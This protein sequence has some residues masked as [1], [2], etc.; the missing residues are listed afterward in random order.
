MK[1]TLITATAKKLVYLTAFLFSSSA[2]ADNYATCILDR[3]PGSHN[4]VAMRAV[5][6]VCSQKYPG[7]YQAIPQGA[8]RG[9]FGYDSGAECTATKAAV[10]PNRLASFAIRL[11]CNRLYDAPNPFDKIFSA[12]AAPKV[13]WSDYKRIPVQVYYEPKPITD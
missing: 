11:A 3:M 8:G 10:T 5:R 6:Q 12:P 2:A 1:K 7:G 4:D 9:W 13:N